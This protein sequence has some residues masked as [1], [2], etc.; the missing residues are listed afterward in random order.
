VP[1]DYL[2]NSDKDGD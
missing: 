2:V 1:F